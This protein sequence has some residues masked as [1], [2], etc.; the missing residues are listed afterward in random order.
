MKIKIL[1]AKSPTNFALVI[2]LNKVPIEVFE[3]NS[4]EYIDEFDLDFIESPNSD[5]GS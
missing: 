5:D 1:G 3:D 2:K 4:F